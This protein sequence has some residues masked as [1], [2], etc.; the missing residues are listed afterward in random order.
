MGAAEEQ[1]GE[2]TPTR[3]RPPC[4]GGGAQHGVSTKVMWCVLLR[5][6]QKSILTSASLTVDVVGSRGYM[7]VLSPEL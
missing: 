6:R 7:L 4:G 2:P 1:E 3:E 5:A